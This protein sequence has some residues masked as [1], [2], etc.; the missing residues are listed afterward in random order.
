M[1]L[2]LLPSYYLILNRFPLPIQVVNYEIPDT[3]RDLK[4]ETCCISSFRS[5]TTTLHHY[6]Q[7]DKQGL[8]MQCVS[9]LGKSSFL[10]YYFINNF[11]F[12]RQ[13]Y[14]SSITAA[15]PQ[16]QHRHKQGAGRGKSKEMAGKE[17]GARDT[18]GMFFLIFFFL[19]RS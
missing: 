11:Y 19:F 6:Y 9:S 1:S 15:P 3:Q 13:N 12:Y 2:F 5:T 4:L 17:T 10:L 8:E 16:S 7:Q 14:N 18:T